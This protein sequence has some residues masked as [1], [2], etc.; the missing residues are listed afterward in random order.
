M[1]SHVEA[2]VQLEAAL[3]SAGFDRA[4]PDPR[5][6]WKAFQRFAATPVRVADDAFLFQ[7]GVYD[8]TG[9]SQFHWGFTR[10]FTHEEDGDY[11]GM[12]HVELNLLYDTAPELMEFETTLWSYDFAT[13]EEWVKAV[14]QL[15]E[16]RM[17]LDRNPVGCEVRQEEV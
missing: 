1:I 6:A 9:R 14:E 3:A 16:F 7:C 17:A 11:E 13:L 10:Q 15:P 8:F 4:N 12:E 2:L 5:A